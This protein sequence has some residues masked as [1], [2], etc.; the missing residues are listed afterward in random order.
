MDSVSFIERWDVL[1]MIHGLSSWSLSSSAAR[2]LSA[3]SAGFCETIW[4]LIF[5]DPRGYHFRA[6]F[7]V[8]RAHVQEVLL[9]LSTS[10]IVFVLFR[11]SCVCPST[12][13][14][15]YLSNNA[16]DEF[17]II[18]AI[19]TAVQALKTEGRTFR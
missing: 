10:C 16:I 4:F 8:C 14:D 13:P 5:P 12:L 18:D 17:H 9:I 3:I 15:D 11:C 19:L 1:L 7:F 6:L 2:T